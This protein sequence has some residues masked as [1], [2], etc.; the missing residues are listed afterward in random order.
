MQD[1]SIFRPAP[2]GPDETGKLPL[3]TPSL[4]LGILC[5][6]FALLLPLISDVLGIIGIVLA[7]TS[8]KEYRTTP[9]LVCSIVGLALAFVNHI[10]G[11]LLALALL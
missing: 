1:D 9:G 5:L 2:T 4:V 8:K 6:V 7:A 11:A 3:H 10:L